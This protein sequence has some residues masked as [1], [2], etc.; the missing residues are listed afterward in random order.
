M[1]AAEGM[2]PGGVISLILAARDTPP[3]QSEYAKDAR[4][5]NQMEMMPD[6]RVTPKPPKPKTEKK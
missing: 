4:F 2:K 3:P 6:K 1:G 5:L